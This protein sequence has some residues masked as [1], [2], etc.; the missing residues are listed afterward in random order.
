LPRGRGEGV[1]YVAVV[2]VE[3]AM[4]MVGI[5]SESSIPATSAKSLK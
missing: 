5:Y 1:R 3:V 2:A 4:S